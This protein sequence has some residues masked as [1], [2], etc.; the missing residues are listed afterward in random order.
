MQPFRKFKNKKAKVD[1]HNFDSKLESNIYLAMKSLGLTFTLQPRYVL[2]EPFKLNGKTFRA[3]EYK[4]DFDLMLN[5]K[6][7][8]LD[9]KGMETPVFKI[10]KKMF[11]FRYQKEVICIKSVRHFMEW[12]RRET[13][14]K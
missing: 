3:I 11:A 12:Y 13:E 5:G 7:Y 6:S 14:M 8:T 10:K 9:A 2:L 4:G 1:G